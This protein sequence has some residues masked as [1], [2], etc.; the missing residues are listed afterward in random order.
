LIL[1]TTANGCPPYDRDRWLPE[2]PGV[3]PDS[4]D[5]E[6]FFEDDENENDESD[7]L[8]LEAVDAEIRSHVI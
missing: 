7:P 4:G 2:P 3:P 8:G 5:G 6:L 1:L